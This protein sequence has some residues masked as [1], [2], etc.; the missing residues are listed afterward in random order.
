MRW[1]IE[2]DSLP[3]GGERTCGSDFRNV[4]QGVCVPGKWHGLKYDGRFIRHDFSFE[5]TQ[6]SFCAPAFLSWGVAGGAASLGPAWGPVPQPG[7][8]LP[9][10]SRAV[11]ERLGSLAQLPAGTWK[12]RVGDIAHGE[13]MNLDES[14]WQA[15]AAGA[16]TTTDAVWFRQTLQVPDTLNGYDLTGARIW[17]QFHANANGPIPEILYFNGRRVA[18]GEDMEPIVLLDDARPGDKVVIAVKL[19]ET[20]DIK[21]FRGATLRIDFPENR[22][23]PEDLRE[24]FLSAA[25]LVPVLRPAIA[26]KSDTLNGA[27]GIVDVAALDT[28]E[29][30]GGAARPGTGQVR[31]SLKTAQG[32]LEALRPLLETATFHQTAIRTLMP[33]GCGR[34]QKR[35]TW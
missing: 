22:P 1:V 30:R 20:V 21:T 23:N 3:R 7:Y 12:M 4:P 16:K 6:P 9:P 29:L 8:N 24:E 35:S 18:M 27:I 14:G 31:R 26:A 17:F 10:A 32:Q 25:V 28:A 11:I 13:A 33:H 19:L 2:G 5:S 15:V 34:G